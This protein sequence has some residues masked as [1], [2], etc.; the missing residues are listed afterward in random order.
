MISL[1]VPP[2]VTVDH[3]SWFRINF[4]IAEVASAER[5]WLGGHML[6]IEGEI[7]Q[8]VCSVYTQSGVVLSF[9]ATMTTST[10][11]AHARTDR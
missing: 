1:H 11:T 9:L 7:L 5:R 6:T 4:L 10:R 2:D 3:H 8:R